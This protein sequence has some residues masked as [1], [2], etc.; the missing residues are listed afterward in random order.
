MPEISEAEFKELLELFVRGHRLPSEKSNQA[1]R[2]R[3][4]RD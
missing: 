1:K 2:A 3:P 4:G